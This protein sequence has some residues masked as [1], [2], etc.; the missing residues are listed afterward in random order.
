VPTAFT[1]NGDGFNDI[2]YCRGYGIEKLL[3]FKIYNR[4]GQLL[5][6]SNSVDEG[7]NGL[8]KDVMQNAD[9]YF[10]TIEAVSYGGKKFYEDGNFLLIR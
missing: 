7:W 6:L 5:F 9:V 1:P 2:I 10:Y 3:N 8:Y 4:W